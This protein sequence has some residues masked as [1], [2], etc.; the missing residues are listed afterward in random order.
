M[1]PH[2]I[3]EKIDRLFKLASKIIG[4]ENP[5]ITDDEKRE[6]VQLAAETIDINVSNSINKHYV[7]A[8][9]EDVLDYIASFGEHL[10]DNELS[11]VEFFYGQTMRLVF[12]NKSFREIS[13]SVFEEAIEKKPVTEFPNEL[14][15]M[16]HETLVENWK[17]ESKARMEALEKALD[18][19]YY[20]ADDEITPPTNQASN[21][22][23]T[24]S[25]KQK[26]PHENK[27]NIDHYHLNVAAKKSNL[28]NA[29][30]IQSAKSTLI[31]QLDSYLQNLKTQPANKFFNPKHITQVLNKLISA[32]KGK[33][34]DFTQTDLETIK[35][36]ALAKIIF[37]PGNEIILP[38]ALRVLSE[39]NNKL[40][41]RGKK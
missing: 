5:I 7:L 12:A 35:T 24:V 14:A 1:D 26:T 22:N 38:S 17:L 30:Q 10:P 6:L 40:Q 16:F 29:A 13:A 11:D 39:H 3:P 28:K 33:A 18:D 36:P 20:S 31:N 27:E 32:L 23:I 15:K 34:V 21:L 2:V 37:Q 25:S 19:F 8:I 4:V 41:Y 9:N